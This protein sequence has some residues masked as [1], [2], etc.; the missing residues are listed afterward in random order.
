[1]VR[2]ILLVHVYIDKFKTL[3]FALSVSKYSIV[4][5]TNQF[6]MRGTSMARLVLPERRLNGRGAHN[7]AIPLAVLSV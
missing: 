1:M 6:L 2:D 5:N 4:F 7:S 3:K